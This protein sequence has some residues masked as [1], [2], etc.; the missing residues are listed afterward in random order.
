MAIEFINDPFERLINIVNEDYDIDC[1]VCIGEEMTDGQNTWGCT[2]FPD[3]GSIPII[4]IHHSLSL[5]DAIEVMAH[6][7]AHIIAGS[8]AEHDDEWEK[9]FSEIHEKFNKG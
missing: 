1:L 5:S 7:F 4:E 6:E 8:D 2:L 9:V 3:D